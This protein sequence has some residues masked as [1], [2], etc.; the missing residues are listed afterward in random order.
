MG[1]GVVSLSLGNP[2]FPFA[3]RL[4]GDA[5]LLRELLLCH[6]ALLAVARDRLAE[7]GDVHGV[8]SFEFMTP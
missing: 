8:T 4:R 5:Q 3:H 1:F 6:G 2:V 7:I